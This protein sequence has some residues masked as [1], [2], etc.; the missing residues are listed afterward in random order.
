MTFTRAAD[1][2]D[3]EMLRAI[4]FVSNLTY[5]MASTWDVAVV[6]DGHHDVLRAYREDKTPGPHS[7]RPATIRFW[8]T[9]DSGTQDTIIRK[10][11]R[12]LYRRGLVE[13]CVCGC[14]GYF[15]LT[16]AGLTLLNNEARDRTR[17]AA[18]RIGVL[19]DDIDSAKEAQ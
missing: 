17:E 1:I 7:E 3:V 10:K 12:R 11:A 8:E 13:G 14:R 6:L 5:G 15:E 2:S 18:D 16:A 19:L 9:Y 4:E